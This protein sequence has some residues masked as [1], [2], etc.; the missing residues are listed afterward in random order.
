MVCFGFDMLI[1]KRVYIFALNACFDVKLMLSVRNTAIH[2]SL[3]SLRTERVFIAKKTCFEFR[4]EVQ[5][6]IGRVKKILF[7]MTSL[8]KGFRPRGL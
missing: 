7:L 4:L 2:R 1:D 5:L 3:F 8:E 6:K